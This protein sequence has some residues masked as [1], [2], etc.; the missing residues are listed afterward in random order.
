MTY[1]NL[2]WFQASLQFR[3]GGLGLKVA[4]QHHEAAFAASLIQCKF[5]LDQV[6]SLHVNNEVNSLIM[7][8]TTSL[9]SQF[10]EDF[11]TEEDIL[12]A[13]KTQQP[14]QKS[15]SSCI[16]KCLL[17]LTLSNPDLPAREKARLWSVSSQGGS[18]LS[19]TLGH[20]NILTIINFLLS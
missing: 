1:Q 14:L 12:S 6:C 3:L 15:F 5:W 4:K 16:D 2:L 10:P 9:R 13:C 18:Q 11:P 19:P 8:Y 7:Q 17:A 20:S